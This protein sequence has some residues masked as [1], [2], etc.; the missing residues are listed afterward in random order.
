MNR[1]PKNSATRLRRS[2]PPASFHGPVPGAR[3]SPSADSAEGRSEENSVPVA[4]RGHVSKACGPG[5][6]ICPGPRCA[7]SCGLSY[8]SDSDVQVPAVVGLEDRGAVVDPVGSELR[9]RLVAEHGYVRLLGDVLL[10]LVSTSRRP[11]RAAPSAFRT[12]LRY[13]ALTYGSLTSPKF[14]LLVGRIA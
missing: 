14:S 3:S 6:R 5:Q 9:E 7:S 8:L 10:Q 11:T 2:R 4:A 13:L 12:E 1:A